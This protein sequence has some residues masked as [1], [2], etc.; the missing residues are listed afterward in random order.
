MESK[1]GMGK[2]IENLLE[3]MKNHGWARGECP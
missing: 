2:Y 1:E 3:G